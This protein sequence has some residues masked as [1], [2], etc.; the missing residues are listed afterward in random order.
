MN[1]QDY[2]FRI[3]DPRIG[4]FLSE[5]PLTKGYPELT[6]YQYASNRPIEGIDWDG[7]EFRRPSFG[8]SGWARS[9]IVRGT[10]DGVVS[11]LKKTWNFIRRD[12]WRA[13]TWENIGLTIEEAAISMPAQSHKIYKPATPRLDAMVEDLDKNLIHGDAYSRSKYLSEFG[14]NM[15]SGYVFGKLAITLGT[16][17]RNARTVSQELLH[18]DIGGYGKYKNA[19]NY[20]LSEVDYAG[21]PIPNLVQGYAE[22][23]LPN[24]LSNSVDMITIENTPFSPPIMTEAV[25]VLKPKGTLSITTPMEGVNFSE[26]A[27]RF[28]LTLKKTTQVEVPNASGG[29]TYTSTT[30]EFIKE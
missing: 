17:I 14:T 2:G 4:R 25:R 20:T 27:K 26:M 1:Q 15:L 9:P 30:A 22:K 29:G 16:F 7:L 11:S 12:A 3:Y 8:T 6:P 23:N 18:I 5:D 24:V 19:I 13:E 21:K 28:G 10:K